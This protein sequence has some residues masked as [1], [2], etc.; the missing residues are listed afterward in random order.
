MSS[1]PIN[2][3]FVLPNEIGKISFRAF[4]SQNKL[5]VNMQVSID[6]PIIPSMYYEYIQAYFDFLIENTGMQ[7][8]FIKED[9]ITAT[10]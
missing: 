1:D 5:K 4:A 3:R 10:K 8:E 9:S 2:T 7:M 6:K